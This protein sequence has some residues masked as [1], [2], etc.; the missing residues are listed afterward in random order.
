MSKK[1]KILYHHRVAAQDGQSVHIKELTAAFKA[2]GHELI[3]VG[4]S[5][6]PKEFGEENSFL[7]LVR[8]LLPRFLQEI[9]ELLYGYRAYYKLKKAYKQHKPDIL[10]ERYNLFLPAGRKLEQ[11]T[12]I[13]YLLEINAP[14]SEER[15][16][17]SGLQLQ[18]LARHIEVETW[19]A[20]DRLFPVSAVLGGKLVAA[21]VD[22]GKITALHNGI[23]HKDYENIDGHK[24]RQHYGLTGKVVLGFTGF[25]REWHKLDHVISMIAN[26]DAENSPHLLIVGEGPAIETCQAQAVELGIKDRVHFAGFRKREEIPEYLAAM[27]IA[28]QPAVTSYASPLKIF[29]YMESGLAIIAPDQ[30]NIR[31]ILVH[32]K[33]ALLFEPQ[34]F[35]AA[36]DQILQLVSDIVLRRKLGRSA[37]N[38][39]KTQRYTWRDNAEHIT[40]IAHALIRSK[41]EI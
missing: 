31:E 8:R 2:I 14:L 40:K 21:G 22:E 13:P 41:T 15:A 24:I 20:A 29:E 3:F 10:Y 33:N 16:K 36:E 37:K 28:L 23:N 7:A 38:A 25:L 39:I 11:K 1:L 32:G 17:Y 9:L 27:D 6:R 26:Y 12:G 18:A 19:Q 4:P 5:L 30:P 34:D 35:V